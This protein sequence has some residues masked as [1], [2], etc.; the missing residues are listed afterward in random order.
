MMLWHVYGYAFSNSKIAWSINYFIIHICTICGCLSW[1]MPKKHFC[2]ERRIENGLASKWERESERCELIYMHMSSAFV[3]DLFWVR[4]DL[5]IEWHLKF[6]V[7]F[8][9]SIIKILSLLL[10]VMHFWF[11]VTP[12][13]SILLYIVFWFISRYFMFTLNQYAFIE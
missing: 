8:F 10:L 7:H 5:F 11:H 13:L 4:L 12:P 2:W 6:L 3:P 9:T 1:W